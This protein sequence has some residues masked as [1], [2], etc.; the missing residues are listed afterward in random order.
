MMTLVV[1]VEQLRRSEIS[2]LFE[3]GAHGGV[4][5]SIFVTT[6]PAGGGPRLH[7]HPYAEVFLIDEGRAAFVVDREQLTVVAGHIVVVPADTPHRFE[8]AGRSPLRVL[9]IQPS[10]NV[11]Q[12]DLE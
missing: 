10:P 3:G 6:W 12:T 5:I 7:K 11:I 2:A 8:N 4:A 1:A 9:S